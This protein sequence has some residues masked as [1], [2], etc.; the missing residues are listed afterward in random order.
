MVSFADL[1]DRQ[2]EQA[3]VML[4]DALDAEQLASKETLADAEMYRQRLS[5]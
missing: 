5:Q 3:L 1:G 4:A 2:I